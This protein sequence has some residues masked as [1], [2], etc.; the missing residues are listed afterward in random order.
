MYDVARQG[1]LY[2]LGKLIEVTQFA[3][4]QGVLPRF[5]AY[6]A[7]LAEGRQG[8]LAKDAVERLREEQV[9]DAANCTKDAEQL[10]YCANVAACCEIFS[11]WTI[12]VNGLEI[13]RASEY[14][15]MA[16]SNAGI[17][18]VALGRGMA[19][20]LNNGDTVR[21]VQ[22]LKL[23]GLLEADISSCHQLSLGASFGN[24]DCR[25]MHLEPSIA[26]AGPVATSGVLP[27]LRF[28]AK[29]GNPSDIILMDNDPSAKQV[30]DSLNAV[31]Q[32]NVK[33]IVTDLNEGLGWLAGQVERQE[34]APRTIVVAYRIEPRAFMDIDFFLSRI[35]NVIGGSADFIMTIGSGDT[36]DEFRNRLDVLGVINQCLSDKGLE[37]ILIKCCKGNDLGD[38][39]ANPVFGL[40]QYASYETLYCRLEKSKLI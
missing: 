22:A 13:A 7:T 9:I 35:G 32:G 4:F 29:P 15:D 23:L 16:L 37:P 28:V 38:M 20:R 34:V 8:F 18:R 27:P 17:D 3:G 25:A 36:N 1:F 19:E 30:Y 10:F 11:G 14:L 31:S 21:V 5:L 24:R 40:S 6:N 12:P 39:R 2:E 33:G 26:P